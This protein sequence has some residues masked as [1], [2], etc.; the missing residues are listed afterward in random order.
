M[1]LNEKRKWQSKTNAGVDSYTF[2]QKDPKFRINWWTSTG[3]F[4]VQWE[5]KVCNKIIKKI[6]QLLEG[7][8]EQEDNIESSRS[9][10]F[11]V[12]EAQEENKTDEKVKE[13]NRDEKNPRKAIHRNARR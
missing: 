13:K 6:T 12:E 1:T 10:S 11:E 2:T 4:N 9:R 5:T 7:K 8:T 3:T